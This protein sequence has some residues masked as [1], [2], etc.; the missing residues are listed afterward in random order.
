[1]GID[2][3]LGTLAVLSALLLLTWGCAA[4]DEGT[5][6][7]TGDPPAVE[8]APPADPGAAATEPAAEAIEAAEEAA[9]ATGPAAEDEE[10]AEAPEQ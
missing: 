4:G 7:L 3:T 10:A 6:D 5:A 2:R 8:A 1:M 9:E